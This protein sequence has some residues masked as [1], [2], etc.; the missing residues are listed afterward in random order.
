M[1]TTTKNYVATPGEI[2]TLARHYFSAQDTLLTGRTTYLRALVATTQE[3]LKQTSG[4][5]LA[6]LENVHERFYA[7]VLKE[8][9][10]ATPV[11]LKD[12]PLVVN[13]KTNFAR[14]SMSAVR[15]WV[16]QGGDLAKLKPHTLTKAALAV[17][18]APRPA[19]AARLTRG[20][21]S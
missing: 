3:R 12:R 19:S 7:A 13:R 17:K 20:L 14:S 5:P 2:A 21:E 1:D 9:Q 11:R 15:T 4:E 16:R 8:A 18:R 6:C 10:D